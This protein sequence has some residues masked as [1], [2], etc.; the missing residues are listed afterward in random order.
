MHPIRAP[1]S[2]RRTMLMGSTL[3]ALLT[4]C[5]GGDPSP[6]PPVLPGTLA[7]AVSPTTL[8]ITAGA[9]G[10]ASATITRGGS[11]S[12]AVALTAE[13]APTGVTVTFG[14]P[15]IAAGA[16]TST[17]SV[18]TTASVTAGSYPI[19]VK[20]TGT[21]VSLAAAT[22]TLNVSAAAATG[23]LAVAVAPTT[24][25]ITA[26][27]SGA[28]TVTVTRGGGFAD[29]VAF[30]SS[31]APSGMTVAFTPP[32]IAGSATTSAVAI[33][34]AGTVSAGTYP[35]VIS[36]AGTG[37]TTA[38]TTLGVTVTPAV[39]GSAISVSY[40]AADAPIWLAYQDGTSGAWTRVT[41]NSGT[42]T[43]QFTA[44]NSRV[45]IAAVDTVGSGYNLSIVY[46]SPAEHNGAGATL[47][48]GRCGAKTV[49]GTIANVSASQL[50]FVT[51]GYS[52][53]FVSPATSTSFQLS[54]VASGPQDL[55][56]ARVAGA[57]QRPDKLILRRGLDIASAGTIPVLDFNAAESF[58]PATA[59]VTL[60]NLG[61]DTASISTIFSGNRGSAFGFIGT[62]SQY[63][64]A[65]GA[66]TYDA[67]PGARLNTGE[68]QSLFAQAGG[69]NA[70]RFSGVYFR[71]P[72]NQTITFG[73]AL[74]T[75]TLTRLAGG[76]YSRVQAQLPLQSEYARSFQA[77]F[78]QSSANRTVNI[79]VTN[80]YSGGAAWDVSVPAF[81]GS[82]W[83]DTWGL[84]NGTPISWSV[85]ASGGAIFLLDTSV[86]DGTPFRN[87]ER[88]STTPL[89]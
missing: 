45:G 35:I 23:T 39:A 16:T 9:T 1:R 30:T 17:I 12:G 86:G 69:S 22:L 84:L 85:S 44:S 74:S 66:V 38:T 6:T 89:P 15:S 18:A 41:P 32:K 53:A 42:S 75:P 51:L 78:S 40:C 27:T 60:G 4:G 46:A 76:A 68:L 33:A 2:R 83:T 80:A 67:I 71:S 64:T 49:N 36:A 70:S 37:V 31:G 88:S 43:Y 26:G 77:T 59:T 20:A 11:F 7:V 65:S 34:V 72:T 57:T 82:G 52:T 29:S 62:I 8:A 48:F 58:A 47:G 79:T 14:S 21:G 55:F 19:A 63:L 81:S 3:L 24:A 5:G 56:A 13:G 87:A 54:N 61:S 28:A 10:A 25:S 50:A 73:P